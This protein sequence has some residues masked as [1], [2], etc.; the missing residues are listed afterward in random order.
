LGIPFKE[1][2][3]EQGESEKKDTLRVN[4]EHQDYFIPNIGVADYDY[5]DICIEDYNGGDDFLIE[6]EEFIGNINVED[7]IP[8]LTTILSEN[9]VETYD[10][11]LTD[12]DDIKIILGKSTYQE[13]DLQTQKYG[14]F[15][16]DDIFIINPK[17]N[18]KEKRYQ[19]IT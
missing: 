7:T 1:I 14:N 3:K 15:D 6:E 17:L 18:K 13:N 5:D 12:N 9:P 10:D 19:G 11:F 4:D 2:C 16:P 8:K